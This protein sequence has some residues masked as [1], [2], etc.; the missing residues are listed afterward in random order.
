MP[1]ETR[2]APDLGAERYGAYTLVHGNRHA[3][4]LILTF[5]PNNYYT[6]MIPRQGDI[7]N[8]KTDKIV[9]R[10]LGGLDIIYTDSLKIEDGAVCLCC[11]S[12]D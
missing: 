6:K 7:N 11:M 1:P 8:V 2:L 5:I 9:G 12:G 10:F 3:F 4:R